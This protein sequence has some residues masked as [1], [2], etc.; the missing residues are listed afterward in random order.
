M[1][2]KAES[3]LKPWCPFCGMDVGKPTEGI[4]RKMREFPMGTCECGAVYVSDTTGHNIGAAMVECWSSL[5]TIS[6]TSPERAA[7]AW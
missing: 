6:G 4:Q 1:G 5:A 3:A 7:P 2:S